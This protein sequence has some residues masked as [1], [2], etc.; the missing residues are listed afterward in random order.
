M[1]ACALV[2]VDESMRA[3]GQ[4]GGLQETG[5]CIEVRATLKPDILIG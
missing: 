2:Q 4:G 3:A 1:I 5:E